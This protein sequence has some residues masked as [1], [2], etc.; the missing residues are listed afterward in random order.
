MSKVGARA[1]RKALRKTYRLLHRSAP[2]WL[3]VDL[4]RKAREAEAKA[5]KVRAVRWCVRRRPSARRA[6]RALP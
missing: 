4:R 2:A 1:T 6:P 5:A 3:L